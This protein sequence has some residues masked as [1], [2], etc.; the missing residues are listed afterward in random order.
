MRTSDRGLRRCIFM[1]VK[2][3]MSI[4]T[5][6][7]PISKRTAEQTLGCDLFSKTELMHNEHTILYCIQSIY[8]LHG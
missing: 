6:F 8:R 2:K 4:I 3:H 7:F 1:N 5:Q